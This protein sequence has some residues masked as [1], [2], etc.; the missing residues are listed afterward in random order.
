MMMKA[1][2]ALL[3][4]GSILLPLGDGFIEASILV[5]WY[6]L[7]KLGGLFEDKEA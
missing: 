1:S 6:G 3:V 7:E 5:D 2:V 4:R